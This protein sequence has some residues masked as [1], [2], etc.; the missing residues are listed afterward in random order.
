MAD[1]RLTR[2]TVQALASVEK[3][4]PVVAPSVADR[5][6]I[7]PKLPDAQLV[8]APPPS[9]GQMAEVV[10]KRKRGRPPRNPGMPSAAALAA[11]NKRSKKEEED[12]CFICFDGG[13][14]VLCDRRV[15]CNLW[16]ICHSFLARILALSSARD[17]PKAY[18]PACVKRDESFFR[19][20]IRWNCGLSDGL[21][22][23]ISIQ[24]STTKSQ[25]SQLPKSQH[26][27]SQYDN[28]H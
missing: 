20:T 12:V 25:D 24:Q 13:K 7:T 19:P 21:E 16:L 18:H 27:V 6:A 8:G 28:I 22:S 2:T 26:K 23:S 4:A 11:A 14:L 15:R 9:D 17:C 10:V 1:G 5:V 3:V